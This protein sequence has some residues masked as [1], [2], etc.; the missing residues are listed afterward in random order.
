[1]NAISDVKPV[2]MRNK[3]VAKAAILTRIIIL[4]KTKNV[5]K[6]VI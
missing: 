2:Q 6:F 4:L 3:L 1:M 5:L